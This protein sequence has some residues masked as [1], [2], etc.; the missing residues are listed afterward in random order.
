MNERLVIAPRL[1]VGPGH[2]TKLTGELIDRLCELVRAHPGASR[3]VIAQSVGITRR[4]LSN[5]RAQSE[6]AAVGTMYY[7]FGKELERAEADAE[8]SL[9][10]MAVGVD[11]KWV[12]SRR[13]PE[14]YGD[15]ATRVE[16]SGELGVAPVE[17]KLGCS[18]ALA[19]VGVAVAAQEERE[20]VDEGSRYDLRR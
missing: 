13:Y 2:G 7:R 10:D 18:A 9:H 11:P 19:S 14:R 5:W 4:T 8:L 20:T 12:L 15:P 17:I 3:E 1:D 6:G 16:L